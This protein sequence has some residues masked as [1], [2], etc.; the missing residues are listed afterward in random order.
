M[1]FRSECN[2]SEA[3]QALAYQGYKARI[4]PAMAQ[5]HHLAKE[6][7]TFPSSSFFKHTSMHMLSSEDISLLIS[8]GE[9][10][11]NE[12]KTTVIFKCCQ[13]NTW[14]WKTKSP[15]QCKSYP[16]LQKYKTKQKNNH[17]SKQQTNKQTMSTAFWD[18]SVYIF[19]H[20]SIP[21]DPVSRNAFTAVTHPRSIQL[22][23]I[24]RS[25][26]DTILCD[27]LRHEDE[28]LLSPFL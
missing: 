18:C 22:T 12:F 25:T 27:F 11:T 9:K 8:G 21:V 20:N 28:L 10:L 4:C 16:S 13:E 17:P 14:V 3:E 2:K 1:S 7:R 6:K 19:H 23:N 15:F 26:Y 24:E 5:S